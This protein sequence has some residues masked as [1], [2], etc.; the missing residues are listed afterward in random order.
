ME[1]GTNYGRS[2][3]DLTNPGTGR[4]ES[5][6]LDQQDFLKIMIEQMRQQNPLEP[7]DNS[8]F[9]SQIAQFDTLDT[10]REIASSLKMLTAVSEL[11]NASALVGRTVTAYIELGPDPVTGFPREPEAVTGVV[12]RITFDTSGPVVHVGERAIPL[13]AVQEI[14]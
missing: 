8:E 13:G 12:D 6:S 7:Q 14:S 4:V 11:A 9:F 5:K 1:I 2:L 10:M 3:S